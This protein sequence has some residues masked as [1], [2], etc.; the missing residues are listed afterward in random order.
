MI[1]WQVWSAV[2]TITS[3]VSLVLLFWKDRKLR[4]LVYHA[5]AMYDTTMDINRMAQTSGVNAIISASAAL[6]KH[7]AA[8]IRAAGGPHEA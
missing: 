3:V 4:E 7:L 2:G 8:V 1:V 5:Q 6:S